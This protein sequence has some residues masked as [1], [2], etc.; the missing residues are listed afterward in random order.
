MKCTKITLFLALSLTTNSA[1]TQYYQARTSEDQRLEFRKI[2]ISGPA[3]L[4]NT[5]SPQISGF[6]IGFPANRNF[7]NFRNVALADIDKDGIPEILTGI[8]KTLYAFKSDSLLWQTPLDGLAIYPP[9]VGDIDNDGAIEIVQVTGGQGEKGRIY[10]FDRDGTP[11]EP[12]PIG[13]NDNWILTAPALSDL[14]N[15]QTLEI[16]VNE[17]DSPSGK[18]HILNLDGTSFNSNWPVS[19]GG[20]P[21]VT[22]SI[23]DIDNDG[24]KDI[25]V[26][27][28]TTQFAFD[29]DGNLKEGWGFST[30]PFQKYS[31]QSPILIDLDQDGFLEVIGATH[32]DVPQYYVLEH[33]GT[34][35][36]NWPID[37][38]GSSWTFNTPTVVPVQG[39]Y[40]I[41]MSRPLF[42]DTVNSMLFSWTSDAIPKAGFPIVKTGGLEGLISVADVDG[43][44]EFELVFGS[45]MAD[46]DGLGYIHAYEM[47]GVTQVPGFPLQ[48]RGWTF[49]NGVSIGDVN[50]NGRMDLVA[51]SNTVE[52]ITGTPDSTYINVY[53]LEVRYAPQKVLWS[54]Y[55]GSNTRDGLIGSDLVSS[56]D[57]KST[58]IDVVVFPNPTDDLLTIELTS[59]INAPKVRLM[60]AT[61]HLEKEWNLRESKSQLSMGQLPAGLYWLVIY[62]NDQL[63]GVKK[64]I[65]LQK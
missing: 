4:R 10:V 61:G 31:F 57:T 14:D 5:P 39:V 2:P 59:R 55:K 19:L 20:T 24:E 22:P 43:D 15:D 53:E 49:M 28:T 58:P 33:D 40:N 51:L 23:G 47:D 56:L 3:H 42:Q 34:F 1:F 50:N 48:P 16:I 13:F 11:I 63:L 46:S 38:P 17:R 44:D 52:N 62:D 36:P 30:E 7:K 26:F 12:W 21:A 29:L 32:G 41:F 45:Q 6:P 18:V 65:K 25:V 27:S 64:L 60:D 54:T 9:S 35:A 8:N 37:V